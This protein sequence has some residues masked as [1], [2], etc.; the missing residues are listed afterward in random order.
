[1]ERHQMMLTDRIQLDVLDEHHLVM[2]EVEGGGEDFL[3]AL[4]KACEHLMEG[5]RDA[6]RCPAQ[7]LAVGV[8]AEGDEQL[9]DGRLRSLAVVRPAR[10]AGL[11]WRRRHR[12]DHALT[13]SFR[14]DGSG[15]RPRPAMQGPLPRSRR[16][17]V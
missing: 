3:R 17:G 12:I 5:P 1:M 11:G 4:P 8:F 13:I 6:L 15:C 10:P 2:T 9:A 16:A 7:A 14:P